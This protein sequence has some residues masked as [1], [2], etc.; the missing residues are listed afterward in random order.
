VSEREERREDG[1]VLD[2]T[3]RGKE[4]GSDAL[5]SQARRQTRNNLPAWLEADMFMSLPVEF[6]MFCE[7][8]EEGD[9]RSV[10]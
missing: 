2:G 5:N 1:S 6:L 9:A 10:G 4:N 7:K 8:R 3:R